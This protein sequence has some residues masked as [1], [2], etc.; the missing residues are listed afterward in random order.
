[1]NP[2][3][4]LREGAMELASILGPDGFTFVET[5]SGPSSGGDYA[6]GEFRREDRR[7]ELHVRSS[8]GLVT[9]HVGEANLRHEDFA[10]AVAATQQ[11][12]EPAR[13]P[14][15]SDQPLDGF[16]HLGADLIRFGHAFTKGTPEEFLAL[17][18]WVRQHPKATGLAG[19]Q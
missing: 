17:V 4:V 6:S 13:Y 7:L 3:E 14:G 16:L 9:Y 10:R 12:E 5:G 1:M 19:L 8:L 18:A 15:F 2:V 11:I